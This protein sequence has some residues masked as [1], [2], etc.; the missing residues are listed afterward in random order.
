MVAMK[1]KKKKNKERMVIAFSTSSLI[2]LPY[3]S[4]WHGMGY[5]F[6]LTRLGD[7]FTLHLLRVTSLLEWPDATSKVEEKAKAGEDIVKSDAGEKKLQDLL[8]ETQALLKEKDK[9]VVQAKQQ[10]LTHLV[11][12][13]NV[14]GRTRRDVESIKQHA[15]ETFATDLL[16]MADNL[17]RATASVLENVCNESSDPDISTNAKLMKSLLVGVDITQKQ[18]MKVFNK[19]GVQKYDPIGETYDPK[20]S[21]ASIEVQDK[22][23][24]PQTIVNI[25]KFGYFFKEKL[26]RPAEVDIVKKESRGKVGAGW[27]PHYLGISTIVQCNDFGHSI[28]FRGQQ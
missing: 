25:V 4:N 17:S 22:T 8:K 20:S 2:C 16:D 23:K 3:S 19:F 9:E 28:V 26:I 27:V 21:L 12:V 10:V 13:E 7:H 6:S 15:R 11:E 18:L 14:R 5:L 1:R 24:E